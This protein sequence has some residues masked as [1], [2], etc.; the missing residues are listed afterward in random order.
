MELINELLCQEIGRSVIEHFKVIE[1]DHNKIVRTNA[2]NAL[3]EVKEIIRNNEFDD[4]MIVDK[5]VSVFNKYNIDVGSCHD[6][7]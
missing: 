6:F 1:I 2:L 5:I 3:E 4:F 7:G